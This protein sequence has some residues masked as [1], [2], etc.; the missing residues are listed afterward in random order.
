VKKD[1]PGKFCKDDI[2]VFDEG[3]EIIKTK[4]INR[5]RCSKRRKREGKKGDNKTNIKA[6][7]SAYIILTKDMKKFWC[8]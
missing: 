4:E 8:K 3:P 7:C 6:V 5:L 2:Y 1:L